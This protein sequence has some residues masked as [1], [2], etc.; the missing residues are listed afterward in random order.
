[1]TE[2]PSRLHRLPVLAPLVVHNR[3]MSEPGKDMEDLDVA[4]E[5]SDSEVKPR[6]RLKVG[7]VIVGFFVLVLVALGI[8]HFANRDVDSDGDGI[9]D[10][11]EIA[12]WVTESGTV[13]VTDPK[14]SDT[15]RDGLTDSE[16][17]GEIVSDDGKSVVYKGLS[18]PTKPDS[19]GD[20]LDDKTE[21]DGW[22]V[23]SGAVYLTAPLIPD[24]DGDG[25]TDGEEA[26]EVSVNN[27]G[28]DVYVGISDPTKMDTDSDGL[29]D[30]TEVRGWSIV[31]GAS[32]W[33]DPANPDTDG[34]GLT[35]RDEAGEVVDQSDGKTVYAGVADPTN[36]DSDGD[37]LDD[38]AEVD[39]SLD[40]LSS[41]TDGDGLSDYR[42][43]EEL[44]TAADVADTD[45]DGLDDG[46]EIENQESQGLD[47]LFPDEK[48]DA[49]TYAWD[50]AQGALLGETA[51]TDSIAWL[52]GNLA[53]GNLS[54][55]PGI[56][57]VA[58][59]V[60]DL[61]D[62]IGLAIRADWI[63]AGYSA[64]GL[65]PTLGDVAVVP[66][67]VSS[68]VGRHPE[69]APLVVGIVATAR[70]IP[71]RIKITSLKKSIDRWDELRAAGA[72][73]KALLR[74]ASG[75]VGLDRT[76][77][78]MKRAG[79]RHD[80]TPVPF[81]KTGREGEQYLAKKY[82]DVLP[83]R[84]LSTSGCVEVCNATARRIDVLANGI[85]HESKVGPVALTESIKRQIESD[86]FLKSSGQIDG[87]HWHFYP[88]AVSNKLGPTKP[89]LDY[90]EKYE[91]PYTIHLPK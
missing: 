55:I 61:R 47:P 14:T 23:A 60:V 62:A 32:Y 19:D 28:K 5:T 22:K 91:I 36:P 40:P 68:F 85:A 80:K 69:L 87:A 41:D 33:T 66:G 77:E 37:G 10:R 35:D 13:Y 11:V 53:S 20:G 17:A 27:D 45:G 57:W 88:S 30:K 2:D 24:T 8:F 81:F 9:S 38:V 84:T 48:I 21:I 71:D 6:H 49:S 58:G 86:N 83:Q 89:L 75:K 54:S 39:L 4:I 51:P 59:G 78:Y 64:V 79:H 46:Y 73:D 67:K 50:F 3:H 82:D 1:M 74:L 42:E 12:G 44:G 76:A 25:L 56:G 63:G 43:V 29:D 52:A 7:A 18:D 90:L 16:E 70:W 26:G 65:V 34:D 72:S 15:D 31:S